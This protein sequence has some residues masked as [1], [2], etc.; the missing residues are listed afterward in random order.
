MNRNANRQISSG[1]YGILGCERKEE[2]RQKEEV[3]WP[4]WLL[5]SVNKKDDEIRGLWKACSVVTM[6]F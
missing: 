1:I 6:L 2:D 3:V 5:L 4:D